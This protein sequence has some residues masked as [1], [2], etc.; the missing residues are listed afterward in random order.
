[1]L[2][3]HNRDQLGDLAQT[4]G[5]AKLAAE[6]AAAKRK[7]EAIDLLLANVHQLKSPKEL[8]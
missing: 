5:P 4:L 3:L 8:R 2:E 7:S 1:M 6:V